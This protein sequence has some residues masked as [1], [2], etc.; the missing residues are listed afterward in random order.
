MRV[1]I[2]ALWAIVLACARVIA[3][4]RLAGA[5]ADWKKMGSHSGASVAAEKKVLLAKAPQI[6]F[7]D[8]AR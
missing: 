6:V 3:A 2:V 4:P 8:D 1:R 5:Q 7:L